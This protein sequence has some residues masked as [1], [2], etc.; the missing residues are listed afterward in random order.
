MRRLPLVVCCVSLLVLAGCSAPTTGDRP[1]SDVRLSVD[2][3]DTETYELTV[4]VVPSTVDT[5]RIT[6]TDGTT[7]TFRNVSGLDAVPEDALGNATAFTA[8]G[9]D[10]TTRSYVLE[11][12]TGLGDE[13]SATPQNA[14]LL[15]L[16]TRPGADDPTRSWGAVTCGQSDFAELT[17]T[18][19]DGGSVSVSNHCRSVDS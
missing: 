3:G 6:D 18:I 15:F 7:R 1:T 16:L 8:T 12:Q 11:P 13:F 17:L 4:A 5:L 10:V 19:A 2:N 9:P 14:T